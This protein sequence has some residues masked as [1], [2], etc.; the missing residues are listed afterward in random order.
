[1]FSTD[2]LHTAREY[3]QLICEKPKAVVSGILSEDHRTDRD[4][5][6]IIPCYNE[7]KYLKKCLDSVVNYSFK[8]SVGVIVVDDGST[9]S[10]GEIADRYRQYPK[11]TV[12]HQK[13][14]GHSEARNIGIAKSSS[15]YLFFLD[16]DDYVLPERLE[17]ML[18][19]ALKTNADS[20]RG[21]LFNVVGEEILRPETET[22]EFREIS[23]Y[24]A[25]G[26]AGGTLFR[27][28]LFK[29]ICFPAGYLYED[30]IMYALLS[31]LCRKSYT[32]DGCV[33]AYRMNPDGVTAKSQFDKRAIHSYW[34]L[35]LMLDT[36][37]KLK[38]SVD[39]PL[40]ERLFGLIAQTYK[41]VRH[42]DQ[43]VST[44]VFIATCGRMKELCRE[45]PIEDKFRKIV[46]EAILLED[47]SLYS[48]GCELLFEAMKTGQ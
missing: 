41:R 24:D 5:D 7:E 9:D 21:I 31:P 46:A 18:D 15:R 12:I 6:L 39:T 17:E 34:I 25:A 42:L 44:A 40:L 38:V 30:T 29:D 8:A 1:M 28:D 10:S 37:E 43:N 35:E 36:L 4:L 32:Y 47:Y 33:Y 26:Y 27:S 48:K 19:F 2:D 13:N 20:V 14:A 3:L 45:I 23:H 22:K 16:S 11:V